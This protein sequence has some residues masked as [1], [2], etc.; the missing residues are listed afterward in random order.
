MTTE[1]TVA[2]IAGSLA[3]LGLVLSKEQKVTE[4][5]KAWIYEL[6]TEL[7]SLLARLHELKML[8]FL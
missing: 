7:A 8:V 1:I 2:L 3:Y 5:R 6:R 4:F